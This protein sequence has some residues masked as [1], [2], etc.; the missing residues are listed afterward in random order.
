MC[1]LSWNN[2]IELFELQ[3]CSLIIPGLLH[4]T[5]SRIRICS[6]AELGMVFERQSVHHF[7]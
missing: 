3:R 1:D 4:S 2:L 7:V 6:S 5:N